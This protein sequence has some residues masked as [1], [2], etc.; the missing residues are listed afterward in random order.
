VLYL[1]PYEML[2]VISA[3][4]IITFGPPLAG[5]ILGWVRRRRERKKQEG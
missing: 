5:M 3:L 1:G 4:L 2:I